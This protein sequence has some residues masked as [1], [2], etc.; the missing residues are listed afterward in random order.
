VPHEPEP[1]PPDPKIPERWELVS[2]EI[3]GNGFAVTVKHESGRTMTLEYPVTSVP[4][5]ELYRA[6]RKIVEFQVDDLSERG[7]ILTPIEPHDSDEQ[8]HEPL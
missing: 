3:D 2:A 8:Y 6:L 1:G 5:I 7:I 4:A